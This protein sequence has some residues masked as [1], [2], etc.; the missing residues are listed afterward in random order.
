MCRC[1]YMSRK[2]EQG[3]EIERT[4][5]I[6]LMQIDSAQQNIYQASKFEDQCV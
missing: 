2:E 5:K 1:L 6:N 4:G 3:R